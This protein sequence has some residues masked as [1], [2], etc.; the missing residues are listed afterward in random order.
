[1]KTNAKAMVLASFA[2]DALALGVHWIYDTRQID[3]KFGR[4]RDFVKPSPPTYHATKQ[5]GDFTHYGDQTLLLLRS[6][7]ECSGFDGGHFG[8][9]WREFFK[10]YTGY[11]D[12]ATRQTLTNLEAGAEMAR[13]GSASEDL[14]GAARIAPL[15]YCYQD[16]LDRLLKSVRQQT[17][18]THRTAEVV[19]GAEFFGRTAWYVLDGR[20]PVE[21]MTRAAD[22]TGRGDPIVGWVQ[23][24]LQSAAE[25][26]RSA[27]RRFG[28]MCAVAAAFP[29]TVH[30]IAKFE[31]RLEEGLIENVMAGGDSAGRGLLAGLV[32]GAHGGPAALPERWCQALNARPEIER[33]LARLDASIRASAIAFNDRS[34]DIT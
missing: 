32:L 7:S 18:F 24:G 27:I 30:L 11:V 25:D 13:A 28:Q 9:A 29:A 21:A 33:M 6:V 14:A 34:R 4:V 1:M 15:V 23:A 22:E 17:G 19:A 3:E 5:Q 2:A 16:D 31:D 26:S 10:T 20:R 12:G 8:R